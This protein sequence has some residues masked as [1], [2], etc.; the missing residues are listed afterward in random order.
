MVKVLAVVSDTF[1]LIVNMNTQPASQPDPIDRYLNSVEHLPPAP[2]LLAQLIGLFRKPDRDLDEVV[3][4]MKKDP[5]LAAE[6]L[7]CCNSAFFGGQE[8]VL[9]VGEA[10]FRIGFYEVYRLSV[11]LFGNSAIAGAKHCH[12]IQVE[13]LWRHSAVTAITASVIAR[14]LGENDGIAFTAGLLHDV[15]RVVLALEQKYLG[16]VKE[17][18]QFGPALNEAEKAAFGFDH[19]TLSARLLARWGVPAQVS[20]PVWCHHQK[21]WTGP[22]ARMAGIVSFSNVM[23]HRIDLK[24]SGKEAEMPQN[25]ELEGIDPD[26]LTSLEE[27]IRAELSR[28]LSLLGVS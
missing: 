24:D 8:P 19:G 18:G 20:I 4:L 11:T 6:V 9:D 15:G 22:Q 17:H 23:A 13:Q 2:T 28:S 16:L 10:V 26:D 27:K 12:G 25:L 3:S 1:I 14:Q 21:A 7:K 5:S